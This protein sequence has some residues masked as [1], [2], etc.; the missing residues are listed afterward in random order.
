[1]AK[2][3]EQEYEVQGEKLNPQFL[4]GL[5][6][7]ET[8]GG[9]KTIK[10]PKGEESHN[11]YNV[12]GPGF[13]AF[14]K[15][16][17][18]KAQYKTYQNPE[19][20]TSDVERLI[21]T[22]YP[23]ALRAKTPEEFAT[24]LK[25]GGYATDKDYVNKLSSTIKS[26]PMSKK[27]WE[28][29]YDVPVEQPEQAAVGTNEPSFVKRMTDIAAVPSAL[30]SSAAKGMSAGVAP[31]LTAGLA[32]GAEQLRGNPTTYQQAL[33][34]SRAEYE[35]RQQAAPG[36]SAVGTLVGGGVLGAGLGTGTTVKSLAGLGAG[37]GGVSGATEAPYTNLADLAM[38][39]GK[40]AAIGG[41]IGAITGGLQ[42]A[43]TRGFSAAKDVV[44][45]NLKKPVDEA[46]AEYE[47]AVDAF[48]GS[49]FG[50]PANAKISE[51][52]KK[53]KDLMTTQPNSPQAARAAELIAAKKAAAAATRNFNKTVPKSDEEVKALLEQGVKAGYPFQGP[54]VGAM[55]QGAADMGAVGLLAGSPVHGALMG[56]GRAALPAI[57]TNLKAL[58]ARG[59]LGAINTPFGQ[60]GSA[61]LGAAVPF[62]REDY[63]SNE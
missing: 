41:T 47:A 38:R 7:L 40:G 46:A 34:A 51:I 10:G 9:K 15:V 16:E 39:T 62:W 45:Q 30:I 26:T 29:E 27:P 8:Q 2:P 33:D 52:I 14:D 59:V 37:I 58:G 25:A 50:L 49:Y 21:T 1:M 42:A 20:A 18:T 55:A 13:D 4:A 35:A 11:L 22:R 24:A 44:L 36:T 61:G 12:K 23:Q 17:G 3:W 54:P 63:G 60:I 28:N 32:Y 48:K 31:Y 43:A 57:G 19:E 6:R 56:A 53:A 5:A